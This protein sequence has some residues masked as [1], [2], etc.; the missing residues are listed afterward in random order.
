MDYWIIKKVFNAYLDTIW[1]T[2][3]IFVFLFTLFVS[4][5][6]V[7]EPLFFSEI[8]KNIELYYET[9]I[10]PTQDIINTMIAWG[11]FIIFTIV[12]L[13]VHRY[14]VVDI[15]VLK[16]FRNLFIKYSENIFNMHYWEYL[17]KKAGSIFKNFD[18]WMDVHFMLLFDFFLSLLKSFFSILTIIIILFIIDWK[19]ALIA[20]S[21]LPFMIMMWF[22]F[23]KVTTL[24][25]K[26]LHKRW[27]DTFWIIWDS[28]NN[29]LLFKT[30]GLNKL[31]HNKVTEKIN[32]NY[33]DQ[34]DVSKQWSIS[35]IYTAVLIMISRL[36]VLWFWVYFLQNW[37]ISFYT[38]FVVFA[39][40]GWIYFPLW[41]IFGQLR[42]IQENLVAAKRFY[43]EFE[44]VEK[45]ISNK[46]L[47]KLNKF[48]WNISF[49]KVSFSYIKWKSVFKKLSF[50]IKEWEKIAFVWNT[51]SWKSSIV[52]LILRLWDIDWWKI[53]LDW[54]DSIKLNK[55]SIRKNIWIV[56]QDNSLFN[57]SIKENLLFAKK[58]ATN[59]DIIKA[60]KDAQADFVFDLEDWIN[61]VIWERGLKLSWWEKQRLS[62]ARLFLKDPKVLILDEATSALDN[63]TERLIQK[64]L[65][66]LMKWRTSVVIAHRLS[67]IQNSDKIYMLENWEIVEKWAYTELMN[68]KWKFFHLANPEHLILN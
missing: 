17:W 49:D 57:L 42:K 21:M 9:W 45:D 18:R 28:M 38:L 60:L 51:W 44:N 65:D 62:I 67:T 3:T 30:L 13:Y 11:V 48:N 52:S 35:D 50:D 19:M 58:N 15:L 20:L 26:E 2:N 27:D 24:K 46:W 34:A 33:I 7:I 4:I 41:A 59:K 29:F 22:Y 23:N 36:L 40:L 32:K 68:K 54:I 1:K 5:I 8:I 61:T 63:K 31:F 14:Y 37:S 56:T 53:L 43:E 39:Y 12:I 47:K 6:V 16:T 25:Q 10:M 55:T 66:K 64:A